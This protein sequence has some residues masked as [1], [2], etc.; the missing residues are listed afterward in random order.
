MLLAENPDLDR[1]GTSTGLALRVLQSVQDSRIA[2]CHASD[3][4][5]DRGSRLGASGI[6]SGLGGKENLDCEDGSSLQPHQVF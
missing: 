4:S 1:A 2:T 6:C 3:G 5:G